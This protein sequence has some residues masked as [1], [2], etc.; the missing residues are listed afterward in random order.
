[1]NIDVDITN[2]E[3]LFLETKELGEILIK[4]TPDGLVISMTNDSMMILPSGENSVKI[5]N[6]IRLKEQL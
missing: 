1:M 6:K 2:G 5:M 3:R 4:E